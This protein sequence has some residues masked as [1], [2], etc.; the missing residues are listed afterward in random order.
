MLLQSFAKEGE[1]IKEEREKKGEKVKKNWWEESEKRH[2]KER[3]QRREKEGKKVWTRGWFG[4][5]HP[6]PGATRPP[7]SP[8]SG[9]R[10]WDSPSRPC[11]L[12]E[13]TNSAGHRMPAGRCNRLGLSPAVKFKLDAK[14]R[15]PKGWDQCK[16]G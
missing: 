3:G 4:A 12:E 8:L 10:P 16:W 15:F 9:A 1:K 7:S 13:L 5:V 2:R 14:S 11:P 6:Y